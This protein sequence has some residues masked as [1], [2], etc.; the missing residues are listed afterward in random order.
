MNKYRLVIETKYET[1]YL[2]IKRDCEKLP[3]SYGEIW[4]FDAITSNFKNDE[5]FFQA[6]FNKKIIESVP[7]KVYI[8]YDRKKARLYPIIYDDY[9]LHSISAELVSRDAKN[10]SES[11]IKVDNKLLLKFVE[12]I[13]NY[14][15]SDELN[16]NFF[17]RSMPFYLKKLLKEYE[18][19]HKNIK[20]GSVDSELKYEFN[21][22]RAQ[23]INALTDYKLFRECLIVTR[24][25]ESRL[26]NAKIT[27]DNDSSQ[28]KLDDYLVNGEILV[29][30]FNELVDEVTNSNEQKSYETEILPHDMQLVYDN[31]GLDGLYERFYEELDYLSDEQKSYIGYPKKLYKK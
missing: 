6:L 29:T 4:K 8:K 11:L 10:S 14:Y 27:P 20:N 22:V 3:S 16:S 31:L 9:L 5:Q 18:I 19:I 30:D 26:K 2:K 13:I 25:Y 12:K 28:L 21:I 23:I 24:A 7:T 1:V 17:R 15:L